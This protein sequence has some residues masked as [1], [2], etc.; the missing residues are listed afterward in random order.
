MKYNKARLNDSVAHGYREEVINQPHRTGSPLAA[1]ESVQLRHA[2]MQLQVFAARSMLYR[3]VQPVTT[4]VLSFCTVI[5][6]RP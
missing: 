1:K 6:W 5:C 2:E 4:D 3:V